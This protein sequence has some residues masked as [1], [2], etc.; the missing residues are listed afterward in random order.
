MKRFPLALLVVDV[1][2]LGHVSIDSGSL[3]I[4]SSSVRLQ[5]SAVGLCTIVDQCPHRDR[6]HNGHRQAYQRRRRHQIRQR[7]CDC[8]RNGRHSDAESYEHQLRQR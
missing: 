8:K 2:V 1:S 3:S 6:E 7:H 5:R 4:C